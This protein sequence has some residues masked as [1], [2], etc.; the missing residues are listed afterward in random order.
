MF[1]A[2][3]ENTILPG[4][5]PIEDI[6]DNENA[7]TGASESPDKEEW[8]NLFPCARE[9]LEGVPEAIGEEAVRILAKHLRASGASQDSTLEK[10]LSWNKMNASPLD[11]WGIES[12]TREAYAERGGKSRKALGC[13]E[14]FM[15]QFCS[16]DCP[17]ASKAIKGD[18]KKYFRYDKFLPKMLADEMIGENNFIYTGELLHTYQD[19]VY[20]PNGEAFAKRRCREK[21]NYEANIRFV[22]EVLAH[23]SDMTSTETDK[24]NTFKNLINLENG[25]YDWRLG[26]LLEHSPDYL[27]TLRIPVTYDQQADCLEVDKFFKTTLPADC[28]GLIEEWLGYVLTPDTDFQ[29]AL[30]LTGSG[31]N[32]KSVCLRLIEA[33]VGS[34]NTSK[35]PLQELER[36]KFKRACLFGM[37]VNV[38]A[39]LDATDL[40]SSS[41]FKTIVVGD[42][43]DAERKFKEP[44]SFRPFSRLIYSAN[45]IPRSPDT[46]VGFYRRLTIIKFPYQFL[47]N[48]DRH[49]ID[50]L[51]TPGELSGLLNRAL[52]GLVRLHARNGFSEIET[53]EKSL[54][55]YKRWNDPVA[56]FLQDKC[57]LNDIAGRI[58]RGQL[59]NIYLKYCKIEGFNPESKIAFF[60][61]IRSTPGVGEVEGDNGQYIF[62]GIK[63]KITN[64]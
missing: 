45:S 42:P 7:S 23:I 5:V 28:I 59:Y 56:A 60:R 53:T 47:D 44:F 37:L 14:P 11:E 34:A 12:A 63:I 58:E 25:M 55:E 46:S 1:G 26:K 35:I 32:G 48:P 19:G 38:F 10:L 49:L 41:Y 21:L 40:E 13:G 62:T 20:M 29:R 39:D 6:H 50:K 2:K 3:K 9:M 15:E 33:M 61:K 18:A 17:I 22:E 43:I 27:S 54:A 24:L 16:Q 57:D 8:G 4:P 52:A 30:V 51:T 64:R 36:H 31:S